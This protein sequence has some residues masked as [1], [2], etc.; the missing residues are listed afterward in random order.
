MLAVLDAMLADGFVAGPW[1]LVAGIA[2]VGTIGWAL[3]VG[4]V[5]WAVA[6]GGPI[7]AVAATA[8]LRPLVERRRSVAEV[9][10]APV[11]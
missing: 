11:A 9:D 3:A 7:G 6:M 5:G 8:A 4:L 10:P 1:A 2:G